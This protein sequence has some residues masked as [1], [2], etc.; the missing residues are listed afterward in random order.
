MAANKL[1]ALIVLACSTIASAQPPD[2][3]AGSGSAPPPPPPDPTP[4]T[5]DGRARQRTFEE[6][7]KPTLHGSAIGSELLQIVGQIIVDRATEAGWGVLS[8]RLTTALDCG[9]KTNYPQTCKVLTIRIQD[10]LAAPQ[11]LLEAAVS[12][13]SLVLRA[14]LGTWMARSKPFEYFV[15]ITVGVGGIVAL[16]SNHKDGLAGAVLDKARDQL[17]DAVGGTC[18]DAVE[19][20]PFDA[21][22]A[23]AAWALGMCVVANSG[24]FPARLQTCNLPVT[25]A[26]CYGETEPVDET[27]LAIATTLRLSLLDTD[28]VEKADG[29]LAFLAHGTAGKIR[30]AHDP[31]CFAKDD[32]KQERD[33][34]A[35][36]IEDLGQLT[37]GLIRQDWNKFAVGA[38]GALSDYGKLPENAKLAGSKF[39][40][41]LA[42]IGQYA[43]TFKKTSLEAHPDAIKE[44]EAATKARREIVES[45]VKQMTN[46]DDRTG[47][48]FSIGGSLAAG[49]MYRRE[50]G[51]EHTQGLS[52]LTLPIGFGLQTYGEGNGGFHLQLSIFDLGQYVTFEE[53]HEATVGTP[54]IRA[55]IAPSLTIGGW[56]CS[57]SVPMYVAAHGGFAPFVLESGNAEW[58]AGIE[59]GAYVPLFDF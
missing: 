5:A 23:R 1:I 47:R 34:C 43:L 38:V 14:R 41:L 58:F 22:S 42:A 39:F 51:G 31:A 45:L 19:K 2:P 30:A 46:R 33:L 26:K 35:A 8:S 12:D 4:V 48:V 29:L 21:P 11:A 56:F 37:S 28:A 52:V 40:K 49:P 55:A 44:Q 24:T 7:F 54:D 25:L 32:K 50:I 13:L 15:K 17:R 9:D 20:L 3:G 57:R 6:Q 10:V 27:T 18:P 16:W 36:L 53:D 59:L